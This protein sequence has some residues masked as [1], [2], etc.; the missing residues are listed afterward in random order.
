MKTIQAALAPLLIIG[1]FCSLG[2][3]EYFLG[4]SRRYLA[5]LYILAIWSFYVYLIYRSQSVILAYLINFHQTIIWI[6]VLIAIP[7]SFFHSKELKM[8]LHELSIV[9]DTLEVLGVS[10]E[11]QQLRN[12][13]IRVIIGWIVFISITEAVEEILNYTVYELNIT[14]ICVKFVINIPKYV[15]LLNALICGVIIGCV[16]SRFQRVNDWLY[17]L[18]SDLLEIDAN[19]KRQN[20]LVL[21]RQRITVGANEYEQY[22]WIIM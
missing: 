1:S 6:I 22:M 14:I 2:S 19:C 10:K 13:I 17:M 15:N 4:Q 21:V 3:F 20:R 18:Y 12:W 5:Y 11:Y 8:C 16:R 7:I 9:D